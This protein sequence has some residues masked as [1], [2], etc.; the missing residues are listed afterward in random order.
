[1]ASAEEVGELSRDLKA[2]RQYRLETEIF[3]ARRRQ[4]LALGPL[5]TS[6]AGQ[7]SKLI[8]QWRSLTSN[9]TGPAI[10]T[11]P[12]LGGNGD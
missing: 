8:A 5:R 6:L 3:D 11:C 10:L 12:D 2:D 1:M 7:L 9:E 4:C